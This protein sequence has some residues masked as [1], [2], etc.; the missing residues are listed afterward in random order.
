M[1]KHGVKELTRGGFKRIL[2][3]GTYGFIKISKISLPK[4]D[5][6]AILCTLLKKE[7][8]IG[9]LTRYFDQKPPKMKD[10]AYVE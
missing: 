7:T 10:I 2:I 4:M 6:K 1:S 3:E 5:M 8:S 9:D